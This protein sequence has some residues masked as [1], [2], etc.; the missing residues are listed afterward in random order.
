MIEWTCKTCV[1]EVIKLLV[2]I[3]Q[4]DTHDRKEQMIFNSLICH[5]QVDK[6]LMEVTFN[7]KSSMYP[8]LI[9]EVKPWGVSLVSMSVWQEKLARPFLTAR[10]HRKEAYQLWLCALFYYFIIYHNN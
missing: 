8:F 5:L 4:G 6:G 1:T 7:C 3:T 9:D 2:N 10:E